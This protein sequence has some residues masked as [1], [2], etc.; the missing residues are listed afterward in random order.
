[1]IQGSIWV[2]FWGWGEGGLGVLD[3]SLWLEFPPPNLLTTSVTLTSCC[4]CEMQILRF[5]IGNIFVH[6]VCSYIKS[7]TKENSPFRKNNPICNPVRI[8]YV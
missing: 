4:T 2:E 5:F 8:I 6:L 1:M 7:V 3:F